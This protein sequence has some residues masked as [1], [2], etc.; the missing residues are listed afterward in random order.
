MTHHLLAI[1]SFVLDRFTYL[2][3]GAMACYTNW[4][5]DAFTNSAESDCVTTNGESWVDLDC[6][7]GEKAKGICQEKMVVNCPDDPGWVVINGR[8]FFIS[9]TNEYYFNAEKDCTNNKGGRLFEP[10]NK[11]ANLKMYQHVQGVSRIP[12]WLGINALRKDNTYVYG[13]SGKGLYYEQ[14]DDNEPNQENKN[15]RCVQ[16]QDH[17]SNWA[18]VSCYA[19]RWYVCERAYQFNAFWDLV[20]VK[21]D[22]TEMIDYVLDSLVIKGQCSTN[23][24]SDG[25]GNGGDKDGDNT[26]GNIS[27]FKMLICGN[28]SIFNS[29]CND[30]KH[31]WPSPIHAQY[32]IALALQCQ[33]LQNSQC[34]EVKH[35]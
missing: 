18:D 21:E 15:A 30:I 11:E 24:N 26:E 22:Q 28:I 17:Q 34:N 31:S 10:K 35:S 16:L 23:E 8:C 20:E 29:Y 6:S 25:G 14:W 1:F 9:S 4:G 3:N 27:K 5:P 7:C 12:Y 13:S 2:S 32:F 19:K 33:I